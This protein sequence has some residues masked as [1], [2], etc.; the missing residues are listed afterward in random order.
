MTVAWPPASR[1]TI[2]R[3]AI[4][5]AGLAASG[6]GA[7]AEDY[8]PVRCD[9]RLAYSG[10]PLHPPVDIRPIKAVPDRPLPSRDVARL[11]E[12]FAR[13]RTLTGAPAL[14]AAVAR[15]GRG[16]WHRTWTRPTH[17]RLWW[18]S[19]GKTFTAVVVL[20][21]VQE[22]KLA[23][24]APVSRFVRGVPNGDVVTLRDCLAHTSGLF[25]ANED[26]LVRARPGYRDPATLLAIARRHGAMFCPGERWRYSNTGYDVLGEIVTR[27]DGRPID[28]AITERIIAP[29][30]L[31]SMRA[32]APGVSSGDVAPAA[33]GGEIIDPSWAGAAGP[34]ASDGRDMAMAWAAL[35]EGRLLGRALLNEMTATLYPMFDPG[36]FYGL[37][38]MVFEVPDGQSTLHWVG[39]AG[40]AP[41]VSALAVYSRADNAIA[42]VAL[43]GGG[44]A[45]A[46][47]NLL[48]K[49]LAK[50]GRP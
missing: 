29:L 10:P 27:V 30:G 44:S 21:L 26:R 42:A 49:S 19:V 50:P 15:P 6:P 33:A 2:L 32:L 8:R 5:L 1:R 39:H 7:R 18:A 47:A 4:A 46:A 37:G 40:G 28:E 41:G 11:D 13:I 22:G 3:G 38:I 9:A 48:L 25:S 14:T 24:D 12:A 20:Q 23:L 36:T 31:S 43:T 16:I 34:I 35:L 45:T 17:P